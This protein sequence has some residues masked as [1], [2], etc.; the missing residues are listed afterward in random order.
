MARLCK[1]ALYCEGFPSRLQC[2]GYR[3][4]LG[5]DRI[6]KVISMI[7]S[8]QDCQGNAVYLSDRTEKNLR[9]NSCLP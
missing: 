2:N 1:T 5:A 4:H 8:H 3:C 7:G 6:R 9:D